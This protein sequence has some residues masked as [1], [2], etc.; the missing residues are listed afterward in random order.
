MEVA[1]ELEHKLNI[2]HS[3][4]NVFVKINCFDALIVRQLVS[5]LRTLKQSHIEHVFLEFDV[6]ESEKILA[7]KT[8]FTERIEWSLAGQQLNC[9]INNCGI[10]CIA[11]IR[12]NCFNEYL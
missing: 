11:V 1:I 12:N 2:R 7:E 5:V 8:T 3:G 6:D 10:I 9:F 4:N